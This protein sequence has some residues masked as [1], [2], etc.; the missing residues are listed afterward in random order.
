MAA[1]R[2]RYDSETGALRRIAEAGGLLPLWTGAMA[3]LFVAEVDKPA[4]GDIGVIARATLCGTNEAAAI[5]TGDRWVSLGLNGLD[6]GPAE[7][8]RVWRL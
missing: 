8:L 2:I 4:A 5:F 7:A 6:F 1:I 3:L